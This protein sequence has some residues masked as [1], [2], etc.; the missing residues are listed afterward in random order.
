MLSRS[1]KT[2]PRTRR[3]TNYEPSYGHLNFEF[4][5]KISKKVIF[6]IFHPI[7]SPI[8]VIMFSSEA[9]PGPKAL[10]R[11]KSQG[12][13]GAEPPNQLKIIQKFF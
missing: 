6:F 12:V 11:P 13:W 8:I 7:F 9:A 2:V 10:E 4:F 1:Y 5:E 3:N